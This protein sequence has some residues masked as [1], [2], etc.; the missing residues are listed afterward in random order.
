MLFKNKIPF[1]LS[2][3]FVIIVTNSFGKSIHSSTISKT[4]QASL[5]FEDG[6]IPG[7]ESIIEIKG[8]LQSTKLT[9]NNSPTFQN[10]KNGKKIF[11]LNSP[12]GCS[13]HLTCCY[14][15][16]CIRRIN[17]LNDFPLYIFFLSLII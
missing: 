13:D 10:F 3:L 5:V 17:N 6:T 11:L 15:S 4:T 7:S 12:F 8:I 1:I 14:G 16:Y 9:E 2:L